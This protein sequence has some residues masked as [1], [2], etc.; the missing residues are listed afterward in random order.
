MRPLAD[1]HFYPPRTNVQLLSASALFLAM[2][3]LTSDMA[4]IDL[5]LPE[6]WVTLSPA[7]VH[8]YRQFLLDNVLF[9]ILGYGLTAALGGGYAISVGM[10][11]V[12][13]A[14]VTLACFA[15]L[16]LGSLSAY[17]PERAAV[18]L[19]CI[20]LTTLDYT[21]L[22]WIGKTDP[23][24]VMAYSIVFFGRKS[25]AVSAIGFFLIAGFHLEQALIISLI[26]IIIMQFE[27]SISLKALCGI[28][29]GIA[30]AVCIFFLYK[31]TISVGTRMDRTEFARIV[32]LQSLAY[33]VGN[34]YIAIVT[35]MFGAWWLVIRAIA[36]SWRGF[37]YLS[38][39]TG[40]ATLA[41]AATLDYSRVATILAM[42]ITFYLAKEAASRWK[43][44]M[45]I[46]FTPAAA[47]LMVAL[48]GIEIRS[49]ALTAF[50]PPF[51]DWFRLLRTT[52]LG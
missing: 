26:H 42:P 37:L 29:A 39:A 25:P 46:G 20:S 14:L 9:N 51:R 45:G 7:N 4:F 52:L 32:L 1:L 13:M 43:P 22:H 16:V 44:G 38:A 30:A 24:L 48:L 2:S 10:F 31:S 28:A 49:G 36:D 23:F 33:F 3:V 15:T 17:G 11:K 41:S 6:Y 35:V 8:P 21:L 27:R 18:F 34:W 47:C 40:L 12:T 19:A 50:G 5:D